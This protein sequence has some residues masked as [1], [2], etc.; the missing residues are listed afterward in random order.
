MPAVIDLKWVIFAACVA[1]LPFFIRELSKTKQ[2][3]GRMKWGAWTI[4]CL[5]FATAIF[6]VWIH[7][8]CQSTQVVSLL[9]TT[10]RLLSLEDPMNINQ[11][12]YILQKQTI[13]SVIN[14]GRLGGTIDSYRL[15]LI[16]PNGEISVW[17]VAE[18]DN[19]RKKTSLLWKGYSPG[20]WIANRGGVLDPNT[21]RKTNVLFQVFRVLFK[22][23][24]PADYVG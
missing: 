23:S 1:L 12:T 24:F 8:K 19:W 7:H 22:W 2:L 17:D 13:A 9:D 20:A 14:E 4:L 21:P 6:G 10:P 5:L 15:L 3:P 16:Q 11:P 18:S